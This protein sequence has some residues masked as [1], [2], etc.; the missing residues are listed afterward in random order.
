MFTIPSRGW[1]IIA[2]L[3]TLLD[4]NGIITRQ[5]D[6]SVIMVMAHIISFGPPKQSSLPT[7]SWFSIVFIML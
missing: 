7:L 1:F 6:L 5:H 2:V 4:Y 3:P